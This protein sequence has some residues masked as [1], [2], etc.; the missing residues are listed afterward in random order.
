M[1]K[2]FQED[3]SNTKRKSHF[4]TDGHWNKYGHSL[5]ADFLFEYF[6]KHPVL[7]ALDRK[8]YTCVE[9]AAF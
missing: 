2:Y 9:S 6:K 1:L 3:Y 7:A 8:N 5:A 4:E